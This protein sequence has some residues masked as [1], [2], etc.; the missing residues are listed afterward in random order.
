MCQSHQKK[1][2]QNFHLEKDKQ[3]NNKHQK[4][5]KLKVQFF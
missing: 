4:E 5:Q 1:T 2:D 3:H